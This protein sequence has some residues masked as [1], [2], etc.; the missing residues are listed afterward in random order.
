MRRGRDLSKRSDLPPRC[1]W[2]SLPTPVARP[3][4]Q[5]PLPFCVRPI[6]AGGSSYQ[7][8]LARPEEFVS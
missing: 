3:F 7:G 2:D 6:R 8:R 4:L 1:E 5:E